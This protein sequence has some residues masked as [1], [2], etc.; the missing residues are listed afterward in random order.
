MGVNT[1]PVLA[2]IALPT[3]GVI[4]LP[5]FARKVTTPTVDLAVGEHTII[6][7]VTDDD[8]LTASDE[9]VI[10]VLAVSG[11]VT[12]DP[13]GTP[14]YTIADGDVAGL[15]AALDAA[16]DLS[17]PAHLDSASAA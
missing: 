3:F 1:L 6:L 13:G 17:T 14:T 8:G 9:V 10:T 16:G 5:I 2:V 11:C 12:T 7:T 4:A 15:I